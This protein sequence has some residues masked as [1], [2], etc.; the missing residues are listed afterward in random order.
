MIGSYVEL[1]KLFVS[2]EVMEWVYVVMWL[3]LI[4]TVP[5]IIHALLFQKGGKL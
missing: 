4:A 2:S 5:Y 1:L 3:C